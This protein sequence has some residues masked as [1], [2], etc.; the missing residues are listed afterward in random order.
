MKCCSLCSAAAV[1][2]G[3]CQRHYDAD[4]YQRLAPTIKA[5]TRAYELAHPDDKKRHGRAYF[6]RHRERELARLAI[7]RRTN[8]AHRRAIVAAS[9]RANPESHCANQARRRARK[10][11]IGGSHKA[12]DI[13]NLL[14]VQ[15]GRCACCFERLLDEY[16]ADHIVALVNGGS[17]GVENLQILCAPCNFSKHARDPVDFLRSRALL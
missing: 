8:R 17:N 10:V 13:T 15:R 4:R 6:R 12:S 2:R 16:H 11:A 5:R 9:R 7:W 3:F 1:A 14:I